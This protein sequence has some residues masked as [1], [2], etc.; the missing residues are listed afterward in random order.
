MAPKSLTSL[1]TDEWIAR[2]DACT[3]VQELLDLEKAGAQEGVS[4]KHFTP[5]TS[6]V[7]QA[8][9]GE[10]LQ[11]LRCRELRANGVAARKIP[12]WMMELERV[13]RERQAA[14]ARGQAFS[15]PLLAYRN[16]K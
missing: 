11:V 6:A 5:M 10:R 9:F 15:H 2:M 16:M 8:V 12:P 3:S 14:N 13:D 1:T 4:P 7:L